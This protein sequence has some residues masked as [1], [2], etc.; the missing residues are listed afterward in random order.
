MDNE[1]RTCLFCEVGQ[2]YGFVSI[3]LVGFQYIFGLLG[4]YIIINFKVS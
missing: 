2:G 3:S 4:I 1:N